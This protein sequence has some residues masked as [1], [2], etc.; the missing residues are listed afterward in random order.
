MHQRASGVALAAQQKIAAGLP[1]NG[2]A[3][4]P[5]YLRLSQAER[6]RLEKENHTEKV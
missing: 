1:G 6:E 3:L 4:S 2:A 5:N